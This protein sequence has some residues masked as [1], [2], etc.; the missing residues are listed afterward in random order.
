MTKQK[1]IEI[2]TLIKST[3]FYAFK[4]LTKEQFSQL[5]T[6]WYECLNPFTDE[7]VS[8][9]VQVA[10][11][12]YSTP[13]VPAD[14]VSCAKKAI[15]LEQPTDNDYWNELMSAVEKIKTTFV[16]EYVGSPYRTPIYK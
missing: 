3:Y 14:I 9:A 5:C 12:E 4:D 8:K 10:L 6:V 7:Q 2:L 16:Q 1:V 11:M 15:L 13:P